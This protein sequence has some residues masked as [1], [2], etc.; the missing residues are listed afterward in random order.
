[1]LALNSIIR[2]MISNSFGF[3]W[4]EKLIFPTNCQIS[5]RETFKTRLAACDHCVA[6][7][8]LVSERT[9]TIRPFRW[10]LPLI[11]EISKRPT[12]CM[13]HWNARLNCQAIGKRNGFS[14]KLH[15]TWRITN[16]S[17]PVSR[18]QNKFSAHNHCQGQSQRWFT[19]LFNYG[20]HRPQTFSSVSD[21][22]MPRIPFWIVWIQFDGP[23]MP[24]N[25]RQHLQ[26]TL[27]AIPV[28]LRKGHP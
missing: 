9:F 26:P 6:D 12:D 5:R 20:D 16:A 13:T 23:S 10:I 7:W 22:R 27:R 1:M 19:C 14:T 21:Q 4:S 28:P 8:N 25:H 3:I 11:K 24:I 2:N 15:L 17:S 18:D